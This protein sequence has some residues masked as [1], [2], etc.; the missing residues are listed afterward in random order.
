MT[1]KIRSVAASCGR[2]W[3][4]FHRQ[5]AAA[6][7]GSRAPLAVRANRASQCPKDDPKPSDHDRRIADQAANH[8]K[9]AI[10]HVSEGTTPFFLLTSIPRWTPKTGHTW[11][12]EKR[13]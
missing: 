1:Q 6:V 12:P 4:A 13:P 9:I 7:R 2:G 5:V 10:D 3:R 11:T 8:K